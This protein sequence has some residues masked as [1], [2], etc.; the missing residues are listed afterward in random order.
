MKIELCVSSVEG[1]EFVNQFQFDRIE[2]CQNLEYGGTT[3]SLGFFKFAK[4]SVNVPVHVLIRPNV[5]HFCYSIAEMKIILNDIE[6]F[7]NE[8]VEGIVVGA[9]KSNGKLDIDFLS[10]LTKRFPQTDFT[11][12]RA[13]DE[14]VNKE[15]A[16]QDLIQLGFKRILTSGSNPKIDENIIELRLL[17]ALCGNKIELMLGGGI[18]QNNIKT[19]I[20][21]VQPSAIHFS[22]TEIKYGINSKFSKGLLLPSKEKITQI[23][24]II[25]NYQLK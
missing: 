8:G 19:L 16:I 12:H 9:L 22:G 18:N 3:P 14:I 1:L 7:V 13:F 10:E 6:L 11:F 21:N 17:N 24:K 20:E 23:V 5:G 15:Q 4:D 2:L 25:Q